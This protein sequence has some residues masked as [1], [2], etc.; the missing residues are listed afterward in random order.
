[1]NK[2]IISYFPQLNKQKQ[3]KFVYFDNAAT[4]LKPE[5]LI[6]E[7]E[8][9]YKND[10]CNIHRGVYNLSENTSNKYEISREKISKFVNCEKEEVVFTSGTTEAIN[11]IVNGFDFKKND[12]IILSPFEHH[13]NLVPFLNLKQ[14]KK[15]KINF[16]ETKTNFE[17]DLKIFEKQIN[18]KT[19]FISFCHI[20]N[21][22]GIIN[23][24]EKMIKIIRKKEKKLK[25]KI[26]ILIDG[27]Q[28]IVFKKIDFKKLDCDF[29]V[30]SAHKIFGEFGLGF[31]IGKQKSLEKITPTKFG[32]GMIKNVSYDKFTIAKIPEC[33]ESGTPQIC[34]VITFSKI[35]DFLEKVNLE[36]IRIYENKL[37]EYFQ[38]K[39]KILINKNKKIKFFIFKNQGM[40]FSFQIKNMESYDISKFLDLKGICI[41]SGL[42]CGEPLIK[43]KLNLNFISRVSLNFYNTKKE[44]DYFFIELEK[45]INKI[46]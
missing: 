36:K 5:I 29:F 28:S 26:Y 25:T 34:Q 41:R 27:A 22:L 3:N 23:P 19:K 43:E 35:I 31:L 33:F 40:I 38:K 24:I 32:G 7:I 39:A 21:I 11:L 12:E 45:I 15:I 6:K 2:K 20:S 9:F 42:L 1:M 16:I 4:S 14:N 17:L 37:I 44:I 46:K 10:N 8:K 13:S 18:E 30:F